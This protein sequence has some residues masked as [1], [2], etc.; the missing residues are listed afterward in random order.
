MP[1]IADMKKAN[2]F[3]KA[4]QLVGNGQCVALVHAVTVIPPTGAW[5]QGD[6]VQDNNNLAPGT[7]I[8][9]FDSNGRY[10]NHTDGTSHAAIFLRPIDGGIVVLDQWNG[11]TKQPPHQRTIRFKNGVG[12]RVDDGSQYHVVK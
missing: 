4:K 11:R 2:D 8:A 7:I 3:V 5:R 10:G 6:Q 12:L 9:T 1:Y